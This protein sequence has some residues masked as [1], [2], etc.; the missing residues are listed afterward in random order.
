M[1]GTVLPG[2]FITKCSDI[3]TALRYNAHDIT[4]LKREKLLKSLHRKAI[5]AG[6]LNENE[7]FDKYQLKSVPTASKNPGK[8][9]QHRPDF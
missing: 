9:W 5:P 6:F 8:T 1:G 7:L 2:Y 4:L 3:T